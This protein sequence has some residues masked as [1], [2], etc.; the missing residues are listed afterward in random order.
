MSTVLVVS[1]NINGFFANTAIK[2]FEDAGQ[3]V[4]KA[5]LDSD[6]VQECLEQAKV[7]F[8]VLSDEFDVSSFYIANFKKKCSENLKRVV[9]FG[10]QE[11]IN[12]MKHIFPFEMIDDEIDRKLEPEEIRRRMAFLIAGGTRTDDRKHILVVDDSGPMLRT[13]MGWLEVKYK[14]SLANSAAVA[15]TQIDK[16]KPDLILLDYEMPI[17]SGPQF[18]KRLREDVN[19]K[20]IPVIFLTAQSDSDSVKN[21]LEL[22]PQGYILKTTPSNRVMEK[23][24]DFFSSN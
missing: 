21:V 4:I 3:E 10:S 7:V 18:L 14:V 9:L 20:D 11:K 23:L 24:E 8:L 16:E 1:D 12:A 17:C 15:R 22:R 5:G 2:E 19:T 6:K 13:I